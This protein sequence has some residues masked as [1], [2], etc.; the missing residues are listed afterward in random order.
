M[1]HFKEEFQKLKRSRTAH[2][3]RIT[4]LINRIN[5]LST[6]DVVRED[7]LTSIMQDLDVQINKVLNYNQQM[8]DLL[9]DS[10]LL[11]EE[12][13]EKTSYYVDI[14]ESQSQLVEAECR[15]ENLC[16]SIK[17]K[18]STEKVKGEDSESPGIVHC[19]EA[20]TGV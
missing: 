18:N 9:R 16:A 12:Q 13:G 19:I 5:L 15:A 2:K 6:V 14:E 8:E 4:V 11:F 1:D 10:D 7:K 20:L 3:G 17:Q